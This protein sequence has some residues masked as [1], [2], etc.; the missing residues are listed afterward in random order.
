MRVRDQFE[1]ELVYQFTKPVPPLRDDAGRLRLEPSYYLFRKS[2]K[3]VLR[4]I[5]C[6]PPQ[7]AY[8]ELGQY[9]DTT[10]RVYLGTLEDWVG[11]YSLIQYWKHLPFLCLVVQQRG[12]DTE[13]S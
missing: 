5:E 3:R 4:L 2:D 1:G 13:D 10:Q 11:E 7:L 8:L 12:A 6:V 9:L